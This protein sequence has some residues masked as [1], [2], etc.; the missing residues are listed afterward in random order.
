MNA[1]KE[2]S[3][4]YSSS[5]LLFIEINEICAE[6]LVLLKTK[7]GK[8]LLKENYCGYPIESVVTKAR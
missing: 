4:F 3:S 8:S 6:N 5:S 7:S 1:F 2:G